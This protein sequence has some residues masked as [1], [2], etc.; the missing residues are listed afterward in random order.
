MTA[1]LE[2]IA[3]DL[4]DRWTPD[5]LFIPWHERYQFTIDVAASAQNAKLPR[6]YTK[7][8]N[9]LTKSWDGERVWCNPPYSDIMPWVEKA[10]VEMDNGCDFIAML[11][12]SNRT[13][14]PWWQKWIE[15]FRDHDRCGGVRTEF[16]A[17]R[18]RFGPL[19]GSQPRFG[20]VLITWC[21][22]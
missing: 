12:P 13:E 6:F 11:L 20:C 16:L 15:P 14:Q 5:S 21:R 8:D 1:A 10:H 19:W 17:K 3:Q 22:P 7:E 2:E 18:P 9:A 4:D